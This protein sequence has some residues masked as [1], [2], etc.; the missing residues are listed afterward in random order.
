MK[1]P[2]SEFAIFG[3]RIFDLSPI[4]VIKNFVQFAFPHSILL[5]LNLRV[6][7]EEISTF[8]MDVVR[9]TVNYREENN[10][11]RKDDGDIKQSG[12]QTSSIAMTFALFE[13]STRPEI[14][15]KIRDEIHGVLEKHDNKLTYEAIKD[16]TY[17]EQVL[18]ETLRKY[19]PL[20]FLTRK[21]N[22]TYKVPGTDL[23]IDKGTMVGIYLGYIMIQNSILM[24][25]IL[26]LTDFDPHKLRFGVLQAKLGLITILKNYKISL[27]NKTVTPIKFY[28]KSMGV[29][30]VDG[31]WL[32]VKKLN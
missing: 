31:V 24:P 16:M 4:E 25:K 6:F 1:K 22:K 30:T 17:L 2:D 5:R 14:Q 21:C 11:Y 27:N 19:P 8:F 23:V 3:R 32:N 13:L 28:H 20:P 15:Q 26:I 9:K 18:H 12:Y 10:I 7:N 29:L